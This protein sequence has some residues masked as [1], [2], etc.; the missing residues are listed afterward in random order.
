MNRH[1]LVAIAGIFL[2]FN[3][4]IVACSTVG[5]SDD[6]ADGSDAE[7][8][9]TS[10]IVGSEQGPDI[11]S[12]EEPEDAEPGASD[13]LDADEN[14]ATVGDVVDEPTDADLQG[15][16]LDFGPAAGTQLVV[17]GVDYDDVLNFRVDPDPSS[18]IVATAAPL[19]EDVVIIATGDASTVPGSTWW[20][21]TINGEGAWANQKF[22]GAE[23]SADSV[24]AE[25]AADLDSLD[26]AT[27]E[28]LVDAVAATRASAE[29]ESRIVYAGEP[30]G[31]D[32]IGGFAVADVLDLGDDSRKGERLRIEFELIYDEASGE[33]GAQEVAGV[34]LSSVT[35]K[36]ICGRGVTA[37]GLCT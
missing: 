18:V 14:D 25:V 32:A 13:L 23:G 37:D 12:A 11:V 35:A 22:L 4:S 17:V 34:R 1:R 36:L 30:L 21:V 5:S 27:A 15:E 9:P 16:A 6:A 2:T 8:T 3:L 33:E 28:G 10:E 24:F 31:F 20:R 7:P 19:A 29:P 26:F